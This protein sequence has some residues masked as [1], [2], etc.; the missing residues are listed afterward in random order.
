MGLSKN[1]RTLTLY[2]GMLGAFLEDLNTSPNNSHWYHH[3]LR[4]AATWLQ[5]NNPY[6]R[7]YSTLANRLLE[8]NTTS[9]MSAWPTAHPALEDNSASI[10]PNDIIIPNFN[11]PEEIHNEDSL[12]SRLAAGFLCS[13]DGNKL[14]I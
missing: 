10:Q 6:L 14:P 11:F 2:S 9:E 13:G 4:N 5:E 1:L 7:S 3:T 8:S 12:Y